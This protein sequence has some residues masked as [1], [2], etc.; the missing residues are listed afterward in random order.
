[1][2][3]SIS[4]NTSTED[5]KSAD[6][7]AEDGGFGG[8]DAVPDLVDHQEAA[9]MRQE[10]ARLRDVGEFEAALAL[11]ALVQRPP[12]QRLNERRV[13]VVAVIEYFEAQLVEHPSIESN[14]Y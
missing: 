4:I 9:L 12:D 13:L 8:D 10:F 5:K 2:Y 1:M 6:Q 7:Y 3:K 14:P 11:E